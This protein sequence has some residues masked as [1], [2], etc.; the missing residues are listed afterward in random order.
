[1]DK[2]EILIKIIKQQAEIFLLN[3]GEFF[4]FGTYIGQQNNIVPFSVYIEDEDDRPASQPL[5]ELF[6]KNIKNG[7]AKGEYLIGALAYDIFIRENDE[8]FDAIMIHIFDTD[9]DY[10]MPFKYYVHENHVEFV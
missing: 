2:T 3:M 6:E 9:N 10:E 5:I 7:L 1:M 4:P 8:K